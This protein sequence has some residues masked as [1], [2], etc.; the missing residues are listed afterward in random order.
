M[1][2]LLKIRGGGETDGDSISQIDGE[3]NSDPNDSDQ[4]AANPSKSSGGSTDIQQKM[5]GQLD[6]LDSLLTKTENAQYSMANQNKQIKSFL[7]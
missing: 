3:L 1:T 4:S 5:S 6:K 7:Q 2:N